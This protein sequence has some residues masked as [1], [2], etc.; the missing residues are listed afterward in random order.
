MTALS[1]KSVG[2]CADYSPVGD[3]ALRYA[4]TLAT[5]KEF[6]LNIFSFLQSPYG[7][8]GA[9]ASLDPEAYDK[10][11]IQKE[12]ELR[13]YYDGRLRD[14]LDVGFRV[15]EGKEETQL[16]RCLKNKEYEVLVVPY[17]ERG[18]YFA[19]KPIEE[20]AN[21]FL[22]PVVLVGPWRRVRYYL[23]AQAAHIADKLHLYDGSWRKLPKLDSGCPT[24]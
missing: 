17:P 2:L 16:R 14:Y 23:N 5:H 1:I 18:V 9:L 6:Q 4:L 3:R 19:N 12:Y 15:C 8:H 22:S 11:L 10:L 13:E 21:R 20:F 24:C 7:A